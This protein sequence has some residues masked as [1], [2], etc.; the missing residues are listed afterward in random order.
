VVALRAARLIHQSAR[1]SL[2]HPMG[3]KCMG[4]GTAP[5]VRA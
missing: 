4:Y 3:F 2:T 1:S 5:S